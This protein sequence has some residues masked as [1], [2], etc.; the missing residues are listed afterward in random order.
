MNQLIIQ[1]ALTHADN[2]EKLAAGIRAEVSAVAGKTSSAV[3][4]AIEKAL[5]KQKSKLNPAASSTKAT[6]PARQKRNLSPE[7]RARIVAAQQKR[8]AAW[9]QG[10]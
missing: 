4:S 5:D 2:L 3:M 9:R 6:K 7:A 10:K 8:W 1:A